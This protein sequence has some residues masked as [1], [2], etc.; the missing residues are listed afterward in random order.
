MKWIK[1]ALLKATKNK[2]KEGD[3]IFVITHSPP[4]GTVYGSETI[5]GSEKIY[6]VL[7]NYP[8]VICISGHSHYSLRN[9]KSI[10]QGSFT[11]INT[12]SIS[13]LDLDNHYVNTMNVR[14]DS[15]KNDFMGLITHLNQDNFIV[16]RIQFATEEILEEKWTINFPINTS[17]FKYAF[18]KRNKKIKPVFNDKN[19]IRLEKKDDKNFLVFNSASHEDYV[20]IY[21]I[22][23]KNQDIYKI[24]LYYSDYYKNEKE[25]KEVIHFELPKDFISDQY[26]VEIYAIDSFDNISEPKVGI[27][28]I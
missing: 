13:Y 20:Y 27:I 9:I 14:I 7:N 17:D 3:P 5:W 24:Y 16:E 19:G 1:S 18:D 21:K 2:K 6:N 26:N 28:N 11:A 23:I 4:K 10:W 8:E 25:R 12:Q 15:A 22:I